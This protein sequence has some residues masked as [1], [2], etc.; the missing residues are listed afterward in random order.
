MGRSTDLPSG[1]VSYEPEEL[2]LR[3]YAGT[4]LADVQSA[5]KEKSQRLRIPMIGTVGGAVAT[6]RNGIRPADNAALPNVVLMCRAIDGIGRSFTA[7]GPTV[8]NVSGFD[9]VKL[10]VGSWGTLATITEVMLRTEPIPTTSRW[11][12]GAGPT[13]SL[14]RPSVVWHTEGATIVNLEGHPADVEQEAQKLQGF[15][16]IDPPNAA[17]ETALAPATPLGAAPSGPLLEIC[18]R[19]K[20]S[21][22]PENTLGPDLSRRWGLI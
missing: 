2:V 7:G 4:P 19:L 8:K 16:E 18:R 21:F 11:F 17:E 6:R 3:V 15:R 12:R 5:L 13:S 20:K 10:L 9:L 1:I 14:F 22:D